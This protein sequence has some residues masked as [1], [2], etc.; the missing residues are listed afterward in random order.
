M[1]EAKFMRI[2]VFFDLPVTTKSKR[3]AANQFRQFLLKDG[4]QML[5]LSVYSRI[6]RGRDSLTKHHKRLC[7]NLPEE[8]S[9]RCLEVTEKQFASMQ[10]L[11]GEL[12]TQEKKVNA[13]QML[14]F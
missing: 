13:N 1:S 8:G 5:Q 9:I 3:R 12:K 10:L 4:Y 11:L 6:V 14:L 2:I 7:Q